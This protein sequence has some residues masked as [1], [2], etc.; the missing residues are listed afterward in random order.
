ME[1]FVTGATGYVGGAVA[2]RLLED[3]HDVVA[4][5][6]TPA[7]A[8][9]LAERGARVVEGD[10]LEPATMREPMAGVDGVF[11]LAAQYDLG[12]DDPAAMERVNVEGTRTVL[13]LVDDLDVPKAVYTSTLGTNSDTGGVAVDETYRY[14]GPHRSVYDRTKWQAHYVVAVPM[15]EAGVPVVTVLPGAVYGPGDASPIQ[16]IL[17]EY[18]TGDLPAVP[19]QTAFSFGHVEDIAAAHVAAME[20]GTPGEEYII[21]GPNATWV[22]MLDLAEALTGIERPRA[23]SPRWF[24]L[25]ARIL[26]ALEPVVTPPE[27]YS[28]EAL[29]VAAGTTY[30]GDNSKA[31]R[32]L[33]IEHRPLREGL[34]ETIAA[35]RERL[36]V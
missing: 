2:D 17:E 16:V 30:I 35:E 24:A 1:Y 4:L 19:R 8:A 14:D 22:E 13:E 15:A 33:G 5:A 12:I 31:V 23:V 11:H 10:I 9:A 28:P 3:G 32:D 25:A 18:L 21:G 20:R 36:G 34:R 7:D 26:S 6:R 27:D 29:R